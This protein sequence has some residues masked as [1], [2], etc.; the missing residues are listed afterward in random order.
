MVALFGVRRKKISN[1]VAYC[2]VRV[3]EEGCQQGGCFGVQVPVV[4]RAG[5]CKEKRRLAFHRGVCARKERLET[6]KVGF[7][8]HAEKDEMGGFCGGETAVEE[9]DI[10]GCPSILSGNLSREN[11]AVWMQG[12][13]YENILHVV[14]GASGA[15]LDGFTVTTGVNENAQEGGAGMINRSCDG[16]LIIRNCTFTQNAVFYGRGA[17][18]L[19]IESA[20]IIENRVFFENRAPMWDDGGYYYDWG[21]YS[22][23]R[24]FSPS[25]RYVSH[26]VPQSV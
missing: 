14:T 10:E 7:I 19:N 12:Y 4:K 1:C 21:V 5:V 20:P 15:T 26:R 11:E 9:R 17:G 18:M 3:R 13:P 24:R 8:H 6:Q 2:C 16:T 25:C 22:G 23:Y